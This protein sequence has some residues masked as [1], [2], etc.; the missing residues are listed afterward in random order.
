[1]SRTP[2]RAVLTHRHRLG[3]RLRALRELAGL[4]NE[5]L[6]AALTLSPATV[7]RIESG[8]RLIRRDEIDT[9]VRA[10]DAPDSVRE[11]L[12]ILADSA[13]CQISPW[14]SRLSAGPDHTQQETTELE[15]TAATMLGYEHAVIHGLL[16]IREYARLVL[17]MA[18]VDDKS[19]NLAGKVTDRMHRQSVLL[20][21]SKH[22]T[23][24]MSETA[25]HWRPGSPELQTEQLRHIHAVMALPN[26]EIGILPLRGKAKAIHPEAFQ[27]YADRIDD[28]DT[29]VVVELV[30]DEV[31]ISEPGSVALYLREFDRLR[32]GAV[33]GTQAHALI[34][35][36]IAD[37]QVD[38][39]P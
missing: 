32:A 19:E 17:T 3:V 35:R 2:G 7:S 31:T 20:D 16:Q 18:G 23:I 29:L 8:D 30:A 1:M 14:P 25:L 22:F 21:Q 15:V 5:D 27:I 9:W 36:I 10:T 11:E 12:A 37:L 6:A 38:G 33:Y 39:T 13:A 34:D 24:I 28:A 4:R 26:V